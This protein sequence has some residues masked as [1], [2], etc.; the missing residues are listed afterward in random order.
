MT[1]QTKRRIR[2]TVQFARTMFLVLF[3][4]FILLCAATADYESLTPM[5]ICFAVAIICFGISYFCD[6]LLG[7]G[8]QSPFYH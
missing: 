8:N 7:G 6:Y 5:F 4:V 3:A 2:K 1:K